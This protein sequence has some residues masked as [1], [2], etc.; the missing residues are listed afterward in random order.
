MRIHENESESGLGGLL[1][2]SDANPIELAASTESLLRRLDVSAGRCTDNRRARHV[3]RGILH[4]VQRDYESLLSDCSL[5]F[6]HTSPQRTGVL[7]TRVR[8][9]V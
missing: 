3:V 8:R 2:P 4:G 7:R 1:A 6:V 9:F 5:R